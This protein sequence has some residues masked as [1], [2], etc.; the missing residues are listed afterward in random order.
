MR[1]LFVRLF[2]VLALC[3]P[4]GAMIGVAA[5]VLETGCSKTA[6][7]SHPNAVDALDSQV[8]DALTVI[9][10]GLVEAR[11]QFG[12]VAKARPVLDAAT[13]AYNALEA[14]WES[15]H[16]RKPDAPTPA[17]LTAKLTSAQTA[18]AATAT[19]GAKP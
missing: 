2:L 13:N 6:V 8:Y 16:A 9:K 11:N 5:F 4:F 18:F 3:V 7:V 1:T 19:L 12:T 14:A 15:Y 10:A 17:A